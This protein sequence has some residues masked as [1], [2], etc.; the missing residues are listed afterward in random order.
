MRGQCQRILDAGG[1]MTRS[2]PVR[3][4]F[5]PGISSGNAWLYVEC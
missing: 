1:E 3:F 5:E 4:R 2:L